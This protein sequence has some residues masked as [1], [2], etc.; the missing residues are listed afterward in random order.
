MKKWIVTMILFSSVALFAQNDLKGKYACCRNAYVFSFMENG[1]YE[2][3]ENS[4]GVD[5]RNTGS[6]TSKGSYTIS[7]GHIALS[8]DA[9][10]SKTCCKKKKKKCCKRKSVKCSSASATGDKLELKWENSDLLWNKN[11]TWEK[12]Y[13]QTSAE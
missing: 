1:R 5:D 13:P 8:K 7:D 4:F 2:L 3:Q 9:D 10:V 12:L 11:G 6:K